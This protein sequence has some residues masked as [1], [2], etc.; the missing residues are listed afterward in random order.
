VR[1]AALGLALTAA[2]GCAGRIDGNASPNN[3]PVEDAAAASV[4]VAAP[5]DDAPYGAA[6]QGDADQCASVVCSGAQVC[7][8]VPIPSDAPTPYPNHKCD[9]DCMAQCMDSCP[10]LTIDGADATAALPSTAH[11]GPLGSQSLDAG[12]EG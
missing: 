1:F 8:V 6:F 7:C 5:P 4:D 2:L 3:A 10:L 9:Y 11:P 12:D